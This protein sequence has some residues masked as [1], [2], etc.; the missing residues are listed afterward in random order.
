M[1]LMS[2]DATAH[3]FW[4]TRPGHGEILEQALPEPG[5]S[6]LQIRTRYSA[7]SRGTETLVFEGRV[8][9]SETERMRA[10]FQEGEFPAPVKYGYVNV[11]VVE[12]GPSNWRGKEVFTL[13]PHQ[14]RF[15]IASDAAHLLP[16]GLPGERAVLAANLETAINALWDVQLK[17]GAKLTVIGAG[18]LGCLCAWLAHSQFDADVELIDINEGRAATAEHLGV[19]FATP[20]SARADVPVVIHTSATQDGLRTSL[21]LGGFEATILELSWFGDK[22]PRVP[23]GAAFHSKRLTLKASQVGHVAAPMRGHASRSSRL[24]MALRLLREPSLDVLIDSQSRFSE[25]PD[26]LAALANGSRSAIC[27]RVHYD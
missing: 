2:S 10:P 25:L 20:A 11:G 19:S 24:Q 8:P 3:A 27:H 12:S 23:L 7:I 22:E 21:E 4:I 26:V 17:H 15:N 13:F 16:R 1:F 18:A 9:H 14:T 6:E 5:H